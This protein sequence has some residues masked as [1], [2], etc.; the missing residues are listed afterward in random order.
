MRILALDTTQAACS[1]A[2]YDSACGCILASEFEPMQ[3]GHAEALPAMIQRVMKTAELDFSGIDRLAV[4]NGPGTF[5]GVRIGLAAARGL[6]LALDL[7]LAAAGSLETVAAG[8]RCDK[9]T[10]VLAAFDARRGEIYAQSFSGGKAVSDPQLIKLEDAGQL[11]GSAKTLVAGT[12]SEMLAERFDNLEPSGAEPLPDACNTAR[13]AAGRKAGSAPVAPV[14]LR[15]PDAKPQTPLL[16]TALQQIRL[17]TASAADAAMLAQIHSASFPQG[18]GASDLAALLN[19]PGSI[20]LVANAGGNN[21]PAGF[22]LARKTVDEAE[23]ITMAVLPGLRRRGIATAL[24]GALF[25]KLSTTGETLRLFLEVGE[26]NFSARQLYD[27]QGF[28]SCG[29]RKNYYTGNDGQPEN[30]LIMVRAL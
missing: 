21:G 7:P 24:L 23:I 22:V 26:N 15:R 28:V 19:M 18:W 16:A 5:S 29:V 14:Y 4:T 25:A 1:V 11:A 3:R 2:V 27:A 8:V 9:D 10:P 17:R 13:L 12:A 30:A 20:A 6:A